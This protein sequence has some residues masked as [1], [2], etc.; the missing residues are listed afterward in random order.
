MEVKKELIVDLEDHFGLT[1]CEEI[2]HPH[3]CDFDHVGSGALDGA[4]DG[5]AL[6]VGSDRAVTRGD[7]FEVST[8]A[9]EGLGE[10]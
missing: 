3:H 5:R 6:G 4:V 9:T 7:V 1:T 8:A 10:A 2:L